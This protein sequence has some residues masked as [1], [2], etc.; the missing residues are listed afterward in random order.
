MRKSGKTQLIAPSSLQVIYIQLRVHDI[1]CA[2]L[3]KQTNGVC[4]S[5]WSTLTLSLRAASPKQ[6]N[7]AGF[8]RCQI[9]VLYSVLCKAMG[10]KV[11]LMP[12]AGLIGSFSVS[13]SGEHFCFK[14]AFLFQRIVLPYSTGDTTE[15]KTYIHIV[16]V[17]TIRRVPLK[18][19]LTS[20][21]STA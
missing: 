16:C 11:V 7:L 14:V 2:T 9:K 12:F 21:L 20:G 3:L 8:H 5:Q 1:P 4:N 13:Q 17:D 19:D 6:A 18:G 15:K 10:C